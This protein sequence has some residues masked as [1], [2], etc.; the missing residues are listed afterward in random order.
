MANKARY[1][2]INEERAVI[3]IVLGDR[4]TPVWFQNRWGSDEREFSEFIVRNGCG[5]CCAAMALSLPITPGVSGMR[6]SF[7][8]RDI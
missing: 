6:I 1:E 2:F 3:R 8:A 5:H 4:S 7:T